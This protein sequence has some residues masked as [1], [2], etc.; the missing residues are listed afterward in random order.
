MSLSL[1]HCNGERPRH[2]P[3]L[4][5]LRDS[6]SIEQ[7]AD[8]VMFIHRSE[9]QNGFNLRGNSATLGSR[10]HIIATRR[11]AAAIIGVKTGTPALQYNV[12]RPPGALFAGQDHQVDIPMEAVN[13]EFIQNM[14]QLIFPQAEKTSNMT[15]PEVRR[16]QFRRPAKRGEGR[17]PP[18][19]PFR[20]PAASAGRR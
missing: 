19:L 13:N 20:G 10:P 3:R 15:R 6:G 7:E 2:W 8:V 5:D 14:G 16:S 12:L 4:P 17:C 11:D 18:G 9:G 1:V